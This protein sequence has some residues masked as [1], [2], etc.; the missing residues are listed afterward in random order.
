MGVGDDDGVDVAHL[1]LGTPQA[2]EEVLP[3]LLAREP[4]V[5]DGDAAAVGDGV[6][7]HVTEAGH[8]D[9]QLHAQHAGSDLADLRTGRFLLLPQS[10]RHGLHTT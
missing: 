4:G 2:V 9:G 6:A 7:V 5:D 10:L 3:R 1:D 8:G